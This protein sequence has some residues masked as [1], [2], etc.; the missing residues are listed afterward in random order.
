MWLIATSVLLKNDTLQRRYK[1]NTNCS[2]SL[3]ITLFKK[4]KVDDDVVI[5]AKF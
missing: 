4:K 2:S 3:V 5:A 1:T